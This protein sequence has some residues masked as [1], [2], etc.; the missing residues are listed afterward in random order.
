MENLSKTRNLKVFFEL[1]DIFSN[2]KNVENFRFSI[3]G[4]NPSCTLCIIL[5][6]VKMSIFTDFERF[7]DL[8]IICFCIF[9]NNYF[10]KMYL[11]D[12][13]FV[14]YMCY[15]VR[16]ETINYENKDFSWKTWKICKFANILQ[17]RFFWFC[18]PIRYESPCSKDSK[19]VWH[20]PGSIRQT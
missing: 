5:Y 9:F 13:I 19:K 18:T 14:K 10:N 2:L 20:V 8:P 16:I 4:W 7:A 6:K 15:F 12:I 1:F 3:S 17:K 11:Y